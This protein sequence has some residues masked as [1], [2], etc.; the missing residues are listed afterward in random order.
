M[1]ADDVHE[2]ADQAGIPWDDDPAFMDRCEQLTG[3][4]HLDSMSEGERQEVVDDLRMQ[5]QAVE[6]TK[7]AQAIP[8]DVLQAAQ[9]D[10]A[11][12]GTVL[13]AGGAYRAPIYS[14]DDV[15]GFFTPRQEGEVWR[16]GPVFVMPAHRGK[17]LASSAVR[18]FMEGRKGRAEIDEDNEASQR[19]FEAAGFMH[20]GSGGWVKE[21]GVRDLFARLMGRDKTEPGRASRPGEVT[22]SVLPADFRE[23]AR[24]SIA[25][26]EQS[27]ASYSPE[28][29]RE[30][31][32]G[33]PSDIAEFELRRHYLADDEPVAFGTPER[34]MALTHLQRWSD[35]DFSL[36]R[37]NDGPLTMEEKRPGAFEEIYGGK[38]GY[39]YQLDPEGFE[40]EPRLMRAERM[41]RIAPKV[42]GTEEIDDVLAALEASGL[43]LVRLEKTAS[44]P[45]HVFIT[46]LP[47]AGKTTEAKKLAKKL[48]LPLISLD[49]ISATRGTWA[50]T[51]DARR[52]IREELDTPHVIEGAQILGLR[53]RDLAKHEVYF[54]DQ[55][56]DVL[57]DRLVSRGWNGADGKWHRGEKS[58][59]AAEKFHDSLVGAAD[60]FRE[61]NSPTMLKQ[62]GIF[63]SKS[64][65]AEAR[66]TMLD[67]Y[68]ELYNEFDGAHGPAHRDDVMRTA[69]L[70]AER[71]APKRVDVAE[72][73][74]LLH[75][76]GISRGRKRHEHHAVEMLK[77]D[78]EF[79]KA[80]GFLDRRRILHAVREHRNSTG[81]PRSTLAKI[82]SDADRTPG[83][84]DSSP[85]A[86]ALAY[87]REHFEELDDDAQL[88][89]AGEI[90][91]AK[92][93]PGQVRTY[94]PETA[95]LLAAGYD[96]ITE[97]YRAGDV[98]ALREI[99]GESMGKAAAVSL[100][101]GFQDEMQKQAAHLEDRLKDRA[102]G[103]DP[104]LLP[105]IE[106]YAADQDLD[107]SKSYHAP[108]PG[109]A[110]VVLG[111]VGK[112]EARR[113]V[114]KTVLSP[115]MRPPGRMLKGS[116]MKVP[117]GTMAAWKQ[118]NSSNLES[119][120]YDAPSKR[121]EVKFKG[122]GHYG[123]AGV[124][125]VKA[126]GL[127]RAKSSGKYFHKHIKGTYEHTKLSA[128]F[129]DEVTR[130]LP[131]LVGSRL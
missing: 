15:V 95:E 50:N 105:A 111:P 131:D 1:T 115:E 34:D 121:L 31:F 127:H 103:V 71:H 73:A 104:S 128:A 109:G 43:N 33:S 112:G 22:W 126:R 8:S 9:D 61:R 77:E 26:N 94:M 108:L 24:E 38:K 81:Q 101:S 102:P 13:K 47:G 78:P 100:W 119:S 29:A 82:I 74:A 125:P 23:R 64:E 93:G 89:R 5:K 106:E 18:D 2:A 35:D 83:A 97:A 116:P 42:V 62:A 90:L 80:F 11:I 57:V 51:K 118:L 88:M 37:V 98:E 72:A 36:G 123:Y 92:F 99:A 30:I 56:K 120:R 32:H 60:R 124:P 54:I 130:L 129:V 27:N 45:K 113:H 79:R 85:L 53:P 65:R 46:G 21:A 55:P 86:R 3:K 49:G 84:G 52:F 67:R 59:S 110:Y 117:A 40:Y 28:P 25:R 70:L 4:R 14:D 75:D 41:T 114:A 87:G 107:T 122:G 19:L 16:L 91:N 68:A 12:E 76:V 66:R 17:G 58:R 39:L 48:G 20:D 63:T 44:A 7:L 6:L 69:R 96:P 10:P